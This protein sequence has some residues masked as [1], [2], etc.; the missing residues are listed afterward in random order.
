[1]LAESDA[2]VDLKV[3]D[4]LKG[5]EQRPRLAMQKYRMPTRNEAAMLS[6]TNL[7]TIHNHLRLR[8][9]YSHRSGDRLY[10]LEIA[11]LG[12]EPEFEKTYEAW[13]ATTRP[14]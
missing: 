8:I 9:A 12:L 13:Q 2:F 7:G 11:S 1:V 6:P 14:K 3:D 5:S 4:V 10:N